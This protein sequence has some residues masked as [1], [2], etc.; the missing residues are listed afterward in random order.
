MVIKTLNSQNPFSDYGQIVKGNRFA[1]RRSEIQTIHSRVLGSSYGNIAV[2]GMPRIGKS[3]L[4]W[5]AL[6]PLKDVQLKNNHII[7]FIYLGRLSSV[8]EFF[9]QLV[10]QVLEELESAVVDETLFSK[11][12]AFYE[13]IKVETIDFEFKNIVQKFFRFL[14]RN[15]YRVSFI[16]DEFDHASE[17]F[18]VED[19]QFLRE[20][21]TQPETRICLIT[22]SRR[23]IQEIEAQNGAISNF[24]GIF[25][26][27][28]LG[29]FNDDDITEYWKSVE[30]FEIFVTDDYKGKIN[31]L[32]G[33]HPFLIDMCNYE[34]F[35]FMSA[36]KISKYTSDMEVESEIKLSLWNNFDKIINL[37]KDEN[38]YD[39]ALQLVLGPIYNVTIGDEQKLLK[40]EFI[41]QVSYLEKY[42]ILKRGL[43]KENSPDLQSYIC[44]SDYFTELMNIKYNDI[45]YWALW[46]E[47]ECV[48]RDLIKTWISEKF[49]DSENWEDEYLKTNAKSEG[50]PE[51]IK[52]LRTTR[53]VSIKKFDSASTHLIDYT[54]SRDMYDLFISSDW[55]WFK[56]VFE[57]NNNPKKEWGKKFNFL[58]DIRNPIAHNNIEFLSTEDLKIAH[59]YC[60]LIN[61]KISKW[62]LQQ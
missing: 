50:K 26:D 20:L 6:M 9:K 15:N 13:K 21:A 32:V 35:N 37:L 54:F 31:Y 12:T 51:G 3:S 52:K 33:H 16:L 47:T 58:A 62:K 55:D 19:F 49:S 40:Y 41:K 11:L 27:L 10:N 46:K 30:T 14:A 39:K 60:E 29:L 24:C 23:T 8:N 42:N 4:V 2:M 38:L 22:I 25:S 56:K 61:E 53:T 48:L 43:I 36:N 44:F 34:V 5:N 17:L 18:K 1:G 57:D 59:K 28:R 45:D 7:S